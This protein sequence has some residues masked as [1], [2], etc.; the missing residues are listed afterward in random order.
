MRI[1]EGDKWGALECVSIYEDTVVINFP[2]G[3]S[4]SY[5][6]TFLQLKCVCGNELRPKKRD[7]AGKRQVLDCGC[8]AGKQ[9]VADG[10]GCYLSLYV[11]FQLVTRLREY[12]RQE[13]LSISKAGSK[14]WQAMLDE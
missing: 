13:N 3:G 12:A 1:K 4:E 9:A 2:R 8:G 10:T 7:F 5:K 14:L 6:D 11:S